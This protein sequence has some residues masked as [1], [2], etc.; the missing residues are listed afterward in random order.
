MAENKK[1]LGIKELSQQYGLSVSTIRRLKDAGKIPFFQPA[2][3]CGRLLFPAD[4]IERAA[5]SLG[6]QTIATSDADRPTRLSGRA[7]KWM[8]SPPPPPPNES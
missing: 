7:P 8:Q 5:Q 2:G 4:A 6:S 3:K 1:L